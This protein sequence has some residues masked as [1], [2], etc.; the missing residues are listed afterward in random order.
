MPQR[1]PTVLAQVN[2]G[3]ISE[4]VLMKS[5]KLYILRIEQKKLLRNYIMI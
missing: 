2:V 4:N 5:N 1:L 3:D